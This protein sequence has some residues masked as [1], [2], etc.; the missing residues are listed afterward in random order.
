MSFEFLTLDLEGGWVM[1]QAEVTS[2][3]NVNVL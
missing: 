1:N 2:Q 3:I